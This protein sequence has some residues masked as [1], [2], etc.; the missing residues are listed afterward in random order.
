MGNENFNILVFDTETIGLEKKFCYD[1]GWGIYNC[2]GEKLK[3]K[4]YITEQIWSNKPLFETAYYANKKELYISKLRGRASRLE[5]WGYMCGKLINDIHQFGIK[6]AYAY[7]SSFDIS[8]FDFTCEWFKTRNPLDYIET[9]DIWGY[10]SALV[11]QGLAQDYVSFAV[12][13]NLISG[14]GNIR[15]NADTWGKFLNQDVN[16]EEEHTGL[17]D[18]QIEK[19]ILFECIS[20]GLDFAEHHKPDKRIS[21]LEFIDLRKLTIVDREKVEHY[22]DFKTLTHYKSRDKIVLK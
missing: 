14:A 16:W 5:K 9:F 21:G 11:Q 18:V 22:F 4:S 2:N 8:V 15:N 20:R 3:E 7:N 13:N 1:L 10:T 17:A 19:E 12:K 6:Q